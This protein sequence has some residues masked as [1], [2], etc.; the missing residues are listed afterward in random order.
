MRITNPFKLIGVS[1]RP[2]F[3]GKEFPNYF[4]LT[5]EYS[6]EKPKICPINKRFRVQYETDARND[7][8]K[9]DKDPGELILKI[10]EILT[11]NYFLNLW[12]GLATLTIEIPQG[13][14]IGDK[15]YFQSEVIDLKRIEPFIDEF[16]V[17]VDKE[18]NETDG[19]KGKR[20]KPPSEEPG[21]DRQ[22]PTF[23]NIPNAFEVRRNEWDK[24]KFD[25][26]SAL[27]VVYAGE[28]EG[29]DF[30]I[31]MDNIYLQMEIKENVKIDPKLL[32]ARFKYGM[33]LLGISLLDF[34][35]KSKKFQKTSLQKDES[36]SIYEK[37]SLFSRAISP[38]LLPMIASLGDLEI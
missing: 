8:F 23:L 30:F 28:Q 12:N 20:K 38:T 13:A 33:V 26:K 1:E 31:N 22:E 29:Y 11:E 24:H 35:S 17:E 4:K 2:E 19:K 7:Y 10:S 5:K 3:N 14:K 9:R 6:K 37:I 25:E 16:C 36:T 32:E 21:D 27:K 34:D 15:L 18:Q